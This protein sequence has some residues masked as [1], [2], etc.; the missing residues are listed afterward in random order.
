MFNKLVLEGTLGSPASEIWSIGLGFFEQS[1]PGVDTAAEL[2]AWAQAAA[3]RWTNLAST[4]IPKQ[5]LTLGGSVTRIKAYWYAGFGQGAS[6]QGEAN[7]TSGVGV[8]SVGNPFQCARA[9]SLRTNQAGRRFRGRFYWPDLNSTPAITGKV[10]TNTAQVQ[11]FVDLIKGFEADA[12]L[13][14]NFRLGVVSQAAAVVTPVTS[15]AVGD[16]LDTQR[17]RRNELPEVY[18]S[19]AY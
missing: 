19:L 6:A 7:V 14:V 15:I 1:G 17:R 2:T 4:E 13:G 11:D 12:G 16:V 8:G 10:T 3:T 18:S 9:V 5:W